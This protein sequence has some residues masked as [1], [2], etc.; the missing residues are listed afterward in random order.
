MVVKHTVLSTGSVLV[1]DYSHQ[2]QEEFVRPQ[3]TWT[4]HPPSA[5]CPPDVEAASDAESPFGSAISTTTT[6]IV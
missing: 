1:R 5:Y 2:I 4:A 3:I 6:S